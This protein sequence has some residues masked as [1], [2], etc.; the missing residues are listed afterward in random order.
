MF[1]LA[2]P[3]GEE[4][5]SALEPNVTAKGKTIVSDR[6]ALAVWDGELESET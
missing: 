1:V 4:M 3:P 2:D 5:L 6:L